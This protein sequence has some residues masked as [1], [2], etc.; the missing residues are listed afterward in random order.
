[1]VQRAHLVVSS[2]ARAAF[3]I[4]ASSLA[5]FAGVLKAESFGSPPE[6]IQYSS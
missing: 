1:V 4:S 3:P 5:A 6:D 2:V